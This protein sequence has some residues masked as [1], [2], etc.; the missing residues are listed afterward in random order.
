MIAGLLKKSRHSDFKSRSAAMKSH[1]FVVRKV[2]IVSG[3]SQNL[4]GKR[5]MRVT[6]YHVAMD[7]MFCSFDST[8]QFRCYLSFL[9]GSMNFAQ[10]SVLIDIRRFADSI[11]ALIE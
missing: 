3:Y 11:C 10:P 6:H 4:A 7:A 5:Q 2:L 9:L 1:L 8:V